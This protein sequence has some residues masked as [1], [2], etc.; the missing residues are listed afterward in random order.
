MLPAQAGALVLVDLVHRAVRRVLAAD[1]TDLGF[2]TVLRCQFD[3]IVIGRLEVDLAEVQVF[4]ERH[5]GRAVLIAKIG[6]Q[7]ANE[8]RGLGTRLHA[9]GRHVVLAFVGKEEMHP[10][11]DQR[12]ADGKAV[13]LGL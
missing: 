12:A 6:R 2:V 3:A 4:G 11:L 13:F 1:I 5:V 8:R 9:L 10:V 7:Q